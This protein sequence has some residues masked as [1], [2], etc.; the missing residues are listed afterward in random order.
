MGGSGA[1][2]RRKQQRQVAEEPSFVKEEKP[3]R[4]RGRPKQEADGDTKSFTAPAPRK[5]STP[6]RP[7]FRPSSASNRV[8]RTARAPPLVRSAVSPPP[9]K[10]KI[11]KPKHLKRKLEALEDNSEEKERLLQQVREMET[12]KKQRQPKRNRSDYHTPRTPNSTPTPLV[13]KNV[14]TKSASFSRE[15]AGPT[16]TPSFLRSHVSTEKKDPTETIEPLANNV[17][18][19]MKKSQKQPSPGAV[20]VTKAN[21]T[22]KKKKTK[23]SSSSDDDSSDD[24]DQSQ[25][26]PRRQRGKRRRGRQDTSE[27]NNSKQQKEIQSTTNED[28]LTKQPNNDDDNNNNRRYC[29]GRKPLTDYRVGK[30]YTGT[31]VYV[32]P[33]GVFF[34]IGCHS[35]AFC[36]VSRLQDEFVESPEQL[37]QPGTSVENIRI[38]EID[39]RQKRITVSLQSQNMQDREQAS[40][41]ARRERSKKRGRRQ[42]KNVSSWPVVPAEPSEPVH[43]ASNKAV[44]E[45]ATTR[46]PTEEAP[47]ARKIEPKPVPEPDPSTMTPAELKRAR[48]L[49]RRA[50]RRAEQG[51]AATE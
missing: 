4:R 34:D 6:Q 19:P 17:T 27:T 36:H 41:V 40:I 14:T 49:A 46:P 39:R 38:L 29:K 25:E 20:T 7:A 8:S 9:S 2:Q 51:Q 22:N 23:D 10:K 12:F 3:R 11:K 43:A 31:V 48:K 1:K 5:P 21:N 45:N 30:L 15:E 32:K 13:S 26:Q 42:S 24:D 18:K 16:K 50:A 33:F 44:A 35:D 37:F 47:V 28:R